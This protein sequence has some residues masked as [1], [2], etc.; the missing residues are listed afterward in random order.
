M[1]KAILG[2]SAA[3]LAIQPVMAA[4][5]DTPGAVPLIERAKLFG[6]PTR[7][8]GKLSP[9]GKWITFIAPRD[10]VLN[11]WVAPSDK[12]DQAR[13]LTAEKGRPIRQSF[14][15][16]DSRSIPIPHCSRRCWASPFWE[17]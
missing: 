5:A 14:W 1:L 4:M 13:P 8:G 15:A 10:G 7:T 3:L 11:I 2:A 9:D 17:R 16:P 12:P 6:N